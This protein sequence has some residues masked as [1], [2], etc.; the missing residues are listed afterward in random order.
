MAHSAAGK[1]QIRQRTG[2]SDA[3]GVPGWE[4][5]KAKDLLKRAGAEFRKGPKLQETKDE[6]LEAGR[7]HTR[8]GKLR[9]IRP[10]PPRGATHDRGALSAQ[11][12]VA[13]FPGQLVQR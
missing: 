8:K 9:P 2:L 13:L 11:R 3:P 10:G 1:G 12:T 7:Q 4:R 5:L 6:L